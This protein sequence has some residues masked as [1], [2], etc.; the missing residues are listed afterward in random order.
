M[1]GFIGS[2][3]AVLAGVGVA[4]AAFMPVEAPQAAAGV[5]PFAYVTNFGSNA[6]SVLNTATNKVVTTAG[7]GDGPG[8]VAITPRETHAYVANED[9]DTVSVINTVTN[10]VVKTVGVGP[11]P[12]RL[13][14]PPTG[15]MPT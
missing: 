3:L 12:M 1:A 4:A 8:A 11:I 14:S 7:V 9:S 15:V 5:T 6:E 2:R 10:K 13:P